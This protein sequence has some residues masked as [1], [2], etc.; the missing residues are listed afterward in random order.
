MNYSEYLSL[1]TQFEL[2]KEY[3]RMN[4]V[5]G[6]KRIVCLCG[7]KRSGKDYIASILKKEHGYQHAQIAHKLKETLRVMFGFS[8]AQLHGSLKDTVDP[9]WDITP[10]RA[11][12]FVGTEMV[13]YDMQKFVPGIDRNFWI[14]SLTSELKL[15]NRNVVISDLRFQ[16]EI[17]YLKRTFPQIPVILVRIDHPHVGL[18]SNHASE[19]NVNLLKYDILFQND[20]TV[21][22]ETTR[23]VLRMEYALYGKHKSV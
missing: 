10:R 6:M 20:K 5:S 13:Q 1:S 12:E 4:T 18:N 14:K 3:A 7:Y 9:V 15:E 22:G 19:T 23:D 16:H 21:L 2:F 11:M 8:D 17:D